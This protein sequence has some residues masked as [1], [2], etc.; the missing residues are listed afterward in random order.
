MQR[1]FMLSNHYCYWVVCAFMLPGSSKK[2]TSDKTILG[3]VQSQAFHLQTSLYFAGDMVLSAPQEWTTCTFFVSCIYRVSLK[4]WAALISNCVLWNLA[5]NSKRFE[6]VV[7]WW[8]RPGN[9]IALA[10]KQ[11]SNVYDIVFVGDMDRG[12]GCTLNKFAAD[13]KLRAYRLQYSCYS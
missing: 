13:I 2:K 9:S 12:T 6:N 3:A 4:S 5:Q 10:T 8:F 11:N 7:T 1:Y